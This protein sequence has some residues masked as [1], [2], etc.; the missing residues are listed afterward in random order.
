VRTAFIKT[1][2]EI[3]EQDPR[4]TLVVGDLGFGV[5]TDFAKRFPNQFLN[6][7]VSEQNMT[8]I[9]AGLA[10]AGR[11]VFTYSIANFPTLRCI[12]QIRNDVCYHGANVKIVAVG[13]GYAYGSLGMTHH[14]TEDIAILRSL[15]GMKVVAPGDPLET[16]HAVRALVEDSSPFYLRL[17]RAGE[18]TLHTGSIDFQVGRAI[19]VRE[20]MD[21][22]LIS[23]G[24]MLENCV[25]VA[26]GLTAEGLQ[27]QV[28]SMHTVK[29]L[30]QAAVLQA[31]ASTGVILT[32]EEH[33]EIGGLGSAVGDVLL[34]AGYSGVFRK[35]ALPDRFTEVAGDCEYLRTLGGLDVAGIANTVRK[36]VHSSPPRSALQTVAQTAVAYQP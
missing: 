3:A 8:G 17:G 15:P 23:T 20:G 21:C 14:A 19:T 26:D 5:V 30:D 36:A 27:V 16:R 32:V 4:I 33:S 13:G 10:M 6:A 29:P 31:A 2:Y 35:V 11:I 28:I 24:G 18:P 25:K 9:A 12:E 1:L 22:T 7:G 34:Y